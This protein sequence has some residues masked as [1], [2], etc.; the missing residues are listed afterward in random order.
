[1]PVWMC[2]DGTR[3]GVPLPSGERPQRIAD[4]DACLA[5]IVRSASDAFVGESIDGTVT[6]WNRAAE[7]LYGYPAV[8]MLGRPAD[9]LYPAERRVDEAVVRREVIAGNRPGGYLAERVRRDGTPIRVCVRAAPVVDG[10]GAVSGVVTMS[11]AANSEPVAAAEGAGGVAV[12]DR[13]GHE[14]RTSLNAIIGFTGTLL[15]R[16]PG[17]LNGEQEHQLRLVQ[18][19]AEKLLSRINELSRAGNR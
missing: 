18:A 4:D 7:A 12:P 3:C 8:E 16:L 11:W 10:V 5:A 9:V 17:P 13:V 15:M 6:V 1:M 14:L 19:S 2:E